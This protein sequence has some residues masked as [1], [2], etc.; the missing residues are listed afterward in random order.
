MPL[1][2]SYVAAIH[3]QSSFQE[4][5]SVTLMGS[6]Q[7]GITYDMNPFSSQHVASSSDAAAQLAEISFPNKWEWGALHIG[8]WTAGYEG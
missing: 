7:L 3:F 8:A 5:V 1:L 6:F 2:K 4:W